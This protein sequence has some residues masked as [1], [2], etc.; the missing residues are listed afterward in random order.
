MLLIKLKFLE[1]VFFTDVLNQA[2]LWLKNLKE[3]VGKLKEVSWVSSRK[4]SNCK[5][6][7]TNYFKS[8]YVKNSKLSRG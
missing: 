4:S 5:T 6:T 2:N 7:T 1:T 8:K 3:V